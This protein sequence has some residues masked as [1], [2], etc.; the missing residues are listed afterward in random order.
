MSLIPSTPFDAV[1]V[2]DGSFVSPLICGLFKTT[3]HIFHV[4]APD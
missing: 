2:A 3:A 4:S 1:V